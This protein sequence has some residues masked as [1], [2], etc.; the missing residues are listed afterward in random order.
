MKQIAAN[1][2]RIEIDEITLTNIPGVSTVKYRYFQVDKANKVLTDYAASGKV[3][4]KTVY[5]PNIISNAKMKEYGIKG[6]L[7]AFE[8]NRFDKDYRTFEGYF[9]G[10]KIIGHYKEVNNKKM[11][12]TWWLK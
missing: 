9:N 11:I 6:F 12:V 3:M 10:Q 4:D 2:G 5:N 8:N 1:G 7:D